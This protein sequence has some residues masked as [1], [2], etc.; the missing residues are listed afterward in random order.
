MQQ[1]KIEKQ[2]IFVSGRVYKS[3]IFSVDY[4]AYTALGGFNRTTRPPPLG[5]QLIPLVIRTKMLQ[6]MY[7]H[8]CMGFRLVHA[9]KAKEIR[10]THA[11]ISRSQLRSRNAYNPISHHSIGSNNSTAAGAS[12]IQT[13]K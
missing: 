2:I 3:V 4:S 13:E 5:C 6:C 7:H 8:I 12:T 1:Q 10:Q 11:N 9:T